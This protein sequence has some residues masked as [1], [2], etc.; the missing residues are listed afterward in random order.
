MNRRN[1]LAALGSAA[2]KV[3]VVAY[4]SNFGSLSAA[5][6]AVEVVASSSVGA[7]TRSFV[8]PNPYIKGFRAAFD[9]KVDPGQ[10]ANLRAYLRVGGRPLTETWTYPWRS[11]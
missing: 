7:A 4:K 11:E 8:V 1:F 9:V 6:G 5:S 3:P 2:A 10:T